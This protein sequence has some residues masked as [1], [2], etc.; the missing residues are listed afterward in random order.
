MANLSTAE[1]TIMKV[2]WRIN[3]CS[4]QKIIAEL[5]NTQWAPN[6]IRTMLGRLVKKEIL[7]YTHQKNTYIYRPAITETEC[8]HQ[9]TKSFLKKVYGE[10]LQPMLVSFIKEEKLSKQDI[11]GLRDLLDQQLEEK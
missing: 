6:T 8:Q 9:E 4:A 1:W 2:I 5:E 11:Q 10:A 3:P 7:T